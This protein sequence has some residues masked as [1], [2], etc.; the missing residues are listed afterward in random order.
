VAEK[1]IQ[2]RIIDDVRARIAS[3]ELSPGDRLPSISQMKVQYNASETPIKAALAW[4]DATGYIRRH[5]GIGSFVAETPP[6]EQ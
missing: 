3:G 5:Q 4:L 1:P 2:Q 6:A